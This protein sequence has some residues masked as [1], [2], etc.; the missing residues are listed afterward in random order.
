MLRRRV[1]RLLFTHL[2]PHHILDLRTGLLKFAADRAEDRIR[3][4][5]LRAML[6]HGPS[7]CR[8][9]QACGQLRLI[10]FDCLDRMD[11]V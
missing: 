1:P 11:V 2:L 10:A 3:E 5:M 8:I 6:R 9:G 4:R 7:E